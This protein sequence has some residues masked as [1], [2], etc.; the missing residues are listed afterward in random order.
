MPDVLFIV[1][2]LSIVGSKVLAPI[3]SISILLYQRHKLQTYEEKKTS[4]LFPTFHLEN[5]I[6]R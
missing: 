6:Q 1:S 5:I 4:E 2:H 3:L